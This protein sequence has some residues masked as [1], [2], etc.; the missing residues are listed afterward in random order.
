[1]HIFHNIIHMVLLCLHYCIP[2]YNNQLSISYIYREE[3][4]ANATQISRL[5]SCRNSYSHFTCL[6]TPVSLAT[7]VFA[8]PHTT[9]FQ[10]YSDLFAQYL[11]RRKYE[12][13]ESIRRIRLLRRTRGFIIIILLIPCH[14][15]NSL[16]IY[17][18]SCETKR[19]NDSACR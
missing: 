4:H 12:A 5:T 19:T 9:I 15:Y 17:Y 18:Q 14:F 16:S 1:M 11:F 7:K 13:Q 8:P 3:R 10:T 6:L 2:N